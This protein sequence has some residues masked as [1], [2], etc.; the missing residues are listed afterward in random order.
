ML[1]QYVNNNTAFNILDIT[2]FINQFFLYK[3]QNKKHY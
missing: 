3:Q 2:Y 1:I